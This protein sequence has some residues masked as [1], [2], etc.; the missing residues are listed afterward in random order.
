MGTVA[1][2]SPEQARGE[3][4]DARTD[5]FSLGTVLYEMA[6]G[7]APFG[8]ASAAV[9]FDAILNKAP[10][11][12]VRLNPEV[13]AELERI[14]DKAIE[15]DREVR[16]QSAKEILVDL[17]RLQ[18]SAASGET[19]TKAATAVAKL[20]MSRRRVVGL[21]AATGGMTGIAALGDRRGNGN[22]APGPSV[23]ANRAPVHYG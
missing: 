18:R 23:G 7:K 6:T 8:G 11:P 21:T 13:P 15:K 20:R 3:A 19:A 10:V 12:P 14:I 17:K 2:M 5:L 4:V 1:Y 9:L 16:Y 22:R